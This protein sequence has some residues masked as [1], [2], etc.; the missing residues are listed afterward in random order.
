MSLPKKRHWQYTPYGECLNSEYKLEANKLT[1]SDPVLP[2][3]FRFKLV[4]YNILAQ[5]LLDKNST[6]YANIN[7]RYLSW[8]YRKQKIYEELKYLN[9][10]IYCFQE[11]QEDHYRDYFMPKLNR[12]GL[13]L[14]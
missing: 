12:L 1:S 6:L 4:S 9:S 3:I 7:Q 2:K 14:I 13:I 10:D 5:D 11:M 8:D